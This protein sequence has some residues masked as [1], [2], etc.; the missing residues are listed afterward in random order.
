MVK[1]F[2]PVAIGQRLREVRE[3][4]LSQAEF[5]EQLGVT[6]KTVSYYEAGK[7]TPDAEFMFKL[8]ELFGVDP[9]WL[10][11]GQRKSLEE[12]SSEECHLL[13]SYRCSGQL[14]DV[15]HTVANAFAELGKEKG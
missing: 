8:I 10:I 11:S 15:I 7:R 12:L 14:K 4:K 5:A 2:D 1:L 13:E 3:G 6:P 9:T